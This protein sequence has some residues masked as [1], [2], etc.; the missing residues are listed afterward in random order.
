M[1]LGDP[2]SFSFIDPPSASSIQ[3]ALTYLRDQG[4]LD[5]SGELTTIG[6]LLASLPVDVVIGEERRHSW[7][8][9]PASQHLAAIHHRLTMSA[10]TTS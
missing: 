6:R 10:S 1:D 3:T 5:A 7:H 9:C 4:A 2:C 8:P